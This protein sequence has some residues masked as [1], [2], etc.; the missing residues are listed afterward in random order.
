MAGIAFLTTGGSLS[1]RET[2]LSRI[3]HP[4]GRD[5]RWN[6]PGTK[7]DQ[8][9]SGNLPG[10]PWPSTWTN[11][12]CVAPMLPPEPPGT[13][14]SPGGTGAGLPIVTPP[15]VNPVGVETGFTADVFDKARAFYQLVIAHPYI[16]GGSALVLGYLIYSY[17]SQR[18]G[19]R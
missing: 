8:F 19:K 3:A 2:G 1:S 10:C 14:Q 12:G 13:T 15:P 5:G 17:F 16:F 4:F 7:L 9:N 11:R 6:A 18:K